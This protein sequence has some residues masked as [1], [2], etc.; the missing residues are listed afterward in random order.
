[1]IHDTYGVPWTVTF[2]SF[3]GL[4]PS[5]SFFSFY[6]KG[7]IDLAIFYGQSSCF[8]SIRSG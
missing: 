6:F 3:L 1:M 8:R 2:G 4:A 5:V 7:E